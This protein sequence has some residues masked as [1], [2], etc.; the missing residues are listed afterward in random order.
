VVRRNHRYAHISSTNNFILINHISLL[1]GDVDKISAS[2]VGT[3]LF[4]LLIEPIRDWKR[5]KWNFWKFRVEEYLKQEPMRWDS[6][7]KRILNGIFDGE[8][9]FENF[10]DLNY[11]LRSQHLQN[12]EHS[13][14]NVLLTE[15]VENMANNINMIMKEFSKRNIEVHWRDITPHYLPGNLM[16]CILEFFDH[17]FG[18]DGMEKIWLSK[19]LTKNMNEQN[20]KSK[21]IL[22][23]SKNYLQRILKKIGMKKEIKKE[24]HDFYFKLKFM[25]SAMD[26]NDSVKMEKDH[27]IYIDSN[28]VPIS[29]NQLKNLEKKYLNKIKKDSTTIWNKLHSALQ[30]HEKKR[31]LKGLSLNQS[32]QSN[33]SLRRRYPQSL[34]SPKQRNSIS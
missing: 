25:A 1:N 3:V 7:L 32:F 9:G 29:P 20:F 15:E 24:F 12:I 30:D 5:V 19:L 27:L 23:N 2:N 4:F 21:F 34:I 16:C 8:A 31:K 13:T 28:K 6:D 17:K 26:F 22:I 14:R 10:M 18:E 33:L 11:A